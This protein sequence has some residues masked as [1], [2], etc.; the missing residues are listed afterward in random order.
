VKLQNAALVFCAWTIAGT[1]ALHGQSAFGNEFDLNKPIHLE[2]KVTG[3]D[4]VNPH[5]HADI[6]VPDNNGGTETWR[7][8][9][10]Q[11]PESRRYGKKHDSSGG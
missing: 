9:L 2:G 5:V 4:W 8:E 3:L 7:A 10:Y 6:G 11:Q 1:A